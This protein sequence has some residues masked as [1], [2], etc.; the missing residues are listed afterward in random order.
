MFNKVLVHTYNYLKDNGFLLGSSTG[1][2]LNVVDVDS[3][4]NENF[5]GAFGESVAEQ[6]LSDVMVQFQ[7]NY[8]DQQFDIATPEIV[9]DGVAS[10]GNSLATVSSASSGIAH[11]SSRDSIRYRPAHTGYAYFTASFNGT[12]IGK[13]GC[14][15]DVNGFIIRVDN[16][17]ATFGYL[18]NGVEKGTDGAAGFDSVDTTGI[19]LTKLNIFMI[20]FGYL[21]VANPT[22]WVKKDK[23]RVL[24]IIKTEG[25]LTETHVNTPVFPIG[26]HAEDGMTISTGSWAGGTIGQKSNVGSRGFAFPNTTAINGTAAEQGSMTMVSTNAL[27]PVLFR[28]KSTFQGLTN[29]V[30]ARLTG[31][32]FEVDVPAGNVIGAVQ[33]QIVGNPTIVGT[34]T[35]ADINTNSSIIEYAH[36]AGTGSGITITGG[37]VIVT[38]TV[39]YVG[40]NKGGSTSD[41]SIDAESLG[42]FAYSGDT[43]AILAKDLGGNAVTVRVTLNWEELF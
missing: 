20:T 32:N 25:R 21:G 7:Y 23:W 15:D 28:S 38:K 2:G 41:A 3:A 17:V 14:F 27:V 35:Y 1:T 31:F 4:G 29:H 39:D 9:G 36:T 19:D 34:P 33:F 5:N 43:F 13:A 37:G 8:I 30:K 42:A 26:T 40:S 11:I 18:K 10:A 16:G 22:L 12:G 24:H 6:R